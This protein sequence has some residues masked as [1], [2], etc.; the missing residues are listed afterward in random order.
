MKKLLLVVAVLLCSCIKITREE[1][2]VVK[3]NTNYVIQ[4]TA[5]T[6]YYYKI[7]EMWGDIPVIDSVYITKKKRTKFT[8]NGND[9]Y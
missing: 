9:L 7:V 4:N 2:P 5:D 8:Y 3:M 6:T 1:Y